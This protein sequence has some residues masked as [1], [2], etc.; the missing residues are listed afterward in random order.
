MSILL[1]R[2]FLRVQKAHR[3][4]K[5]CIAS[6]NLS[7]KADNGVPSLHQSWCVTLRKPRHPCLMT[8]LH[9]SQRH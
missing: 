9:F 7:G 4:G 6:V 1:E 8:I 5:R 3:R 2:G